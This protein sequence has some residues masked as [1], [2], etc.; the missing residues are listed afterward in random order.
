MQ[1][2]RLGETA[3]NKNL[4][5]ASEWHEICEASVEEQ[6]PLGGLQREATMERG[7]IGTVM[8]P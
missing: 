8:N 6:D 2:C 5:G 7:R 3:E 4:S 1:P